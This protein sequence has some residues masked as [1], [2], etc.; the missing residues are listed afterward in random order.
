[1]V[2]N[3]PGALEPLS[4]PSAEFIKAHVYVPGTILR[5]FERENRSNPLPDIVQM[6][7]RELGVSTVERFDRARK[8]LW[9]FPVNRN[10]PRPRPLPEIEGMPM[11]IPAGSNR[12]TFYG[13]RIKT[14]PDPN[15]YFAI[16]S[17]LPPTGD[18]DDIGMDDCRTIST[19]PS[20]EEEE[21]LD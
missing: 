11:A 8:K 2:I 21:T 18:D 5:E 1:M 20:S 9:D 3:I 14:Q 10:A 7:I 16:D 19:N 15:A 13:H 12:Y 17:D 6:I 4:P